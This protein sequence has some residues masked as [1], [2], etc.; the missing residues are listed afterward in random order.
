MKSIRQG[1]SVAR[2]SRSMRRES[3]QALV[4]FAIMIP[5]FLLL[6]LGGADVL[7]AFSAKS[8]LNTVAAQTAQCLQQNNGSCPSGPQPYAQAIA[9]GLGL[10]ASQL[11]A[12]Q[13][14]CTGIPKC[15]NV[16]VNYVDA[17]IFKGFFP[18]VSMQST[19]QYTTP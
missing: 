12:S 5:F 11:T 7:M 19:A 17:P 4:E 6:L 9:P 16:T 10:N 3:G 14:A 2:R 1:G 18:R 13:S 15:F 8:S